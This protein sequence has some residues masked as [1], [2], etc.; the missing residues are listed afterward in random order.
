MA[1]ELQLL[2]EIQFLMFGIP[3]QPLGLSKVL[4]M[5]HSAL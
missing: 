3:L 5:P 1:M 4:Q 2:L